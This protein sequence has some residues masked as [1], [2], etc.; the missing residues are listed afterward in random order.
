QAE[1]Q[2]RR[3]AMAQKSA[4]EAAQSRAEAEQIRL[5]SELEN[6]NSRSSTPSTP[7]RAGNNPE[8][9]RS[10]EHAKVLEEMRDR[11]HKLQL[12][13][14]HLESGLEKANLDATPL[15]KANAEIDQ[16]KS[17]LALAREQLGS[18]QQSLESLERKY[19]STRRKY[20]SSK[21]K[22]GTCKNRLENER[23]IV[24]K[25]QETL[26]PAAYKS[27]GVTHETLGAFL[28]AM[29]LPP[30]GDEG[31]AGPKEESE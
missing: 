16:L 9:S 5:R 14:S 28:S 21:E 29:G 27:L 31:N 4:A 6:I 3:E 11:E 30:V 13:R 17:D 26:T 23:S 1:Q 24:K 8:F 20:E 22:L 7:S 10:E 25:L 19:S 2:A 18:T 15:N 12:R